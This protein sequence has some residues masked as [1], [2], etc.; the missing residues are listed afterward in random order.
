MVL[1]LRQPSPDQWRNSK[2]LGKVFDED[3]KYQEELD[4]FFTPDREEEAVDFCRGK[5]G[6]PCPIMEQCLIFAL[7]NNEKSGVFG[8]TPELDRKA[9]R[10]KWPLRRGKDPRPEWQLFEPGEPASW[11][12]DEELGDDNDD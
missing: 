2:C 5:D 8:G 12:A 10:K 11:Y 1:H 3:G 4:P 6:T 9:I 7:V